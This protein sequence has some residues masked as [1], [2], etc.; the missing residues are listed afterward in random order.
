MIYAR[1]GI[2]L[3]MELN[4]QAPDGCHVNLVYLETPKKRVTLLTEQYPSRKELHDALDAQ[5]ATVLFARARQLCPA[6]N[7]REQRN[8]TAMRELP[9]EPIDVACDCLA[10][11]GVPCDGN[12]AE[13]RDDRKRRLRDFLIWLAE[14]NF[15]ATK[16]LTKVRARKVLDA[17]GIKVHAQNSWANPY[18]ASMGLAIL[19]PQTQLFWCLF[20]GNRN[21]TKPCA[22]WLT[23]GKNFS[24]PE[25]G[26]FRDEREIA[27]ALREWYRE[28]WVVSDTHPRTMVLVHKSNKPDAEKR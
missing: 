18:S 10:P 3:E 26:P 19:Q 13:C 24:R 11:P 2:F 14:Q 7:E 15:P 12:S 6:I 21:K 16:K 1:D 28:E 25:R 22:A 27:L 5:V 20:I 17:M 4:H 9:F 8:L 23:W